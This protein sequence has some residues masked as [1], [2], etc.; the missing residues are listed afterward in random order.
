MLRILFTVAVGVSLHAATPLYQPSI[1]KSEDFSVVTGSAGIDAAVQH[2][3]M[4]SVRLDAPKG[5]MP[6]VVRFP[7]VNL[8]IGKRYELSAWVQTD[9]LA[10]GD[11]DRSPIATGAALSMASMPFDV[12]STSLGGTRP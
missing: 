2:N 10:A 1:E 3:G 8:V 9:N 11:L 12:H 6:S 5:R 4:K 7:A